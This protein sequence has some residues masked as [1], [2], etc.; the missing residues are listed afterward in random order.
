M[1]PH[2]PGGFT[3]QQHLNDS[4]SINKIKAGGWD[5][6]ALQ[7]KVSFHPFPIMTDYLLFKLLIWL[8]YIILVHVSCSTCDMG[9]GR[10][11]CIQLRGISA[12]LHCTKEWIVWYIVHTCKWLLQIM[13]KFRRLE[14]SGNTFMP[15]LSG[16]W[17]HATDESHPSC[18]GF[19]CRSL[20]SFISF[21]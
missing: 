8:I 19:L 15:E 4:T 13:Q 1:I 14:E 12:C 6:I 16:H 2:T 20:R 11:W 10:M 17:I 9:Q 21:F 18:G 3:L 5:Y 7:N